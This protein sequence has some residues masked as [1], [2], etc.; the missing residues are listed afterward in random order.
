MQATSPHTTCNQEC[1]ALGTTCNAIEMAKVHTEARLLEVMALFNGVTEC[2]HLAWTDSPYTGTPTATIPDGHT[3]YM[4]ILQHPGT[5]PDCG[6]NSG[7]ESGP[8]AHHAIC[9][10]NVV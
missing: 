10:C 9:Y 3:T 7:Q 8:Y 2:Q 6:Y 1:G 5:I 4:C